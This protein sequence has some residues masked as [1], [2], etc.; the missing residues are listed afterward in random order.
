MTNRTILGEVEVNILIKQMELLGLV[1]DAFEASWMLAIAGCGVAQEK[2][3][4]WRGLAVAAKKL[5]VGVMEV[6]QL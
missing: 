4:F 3:D 6:T 2:P 1:I 5:D